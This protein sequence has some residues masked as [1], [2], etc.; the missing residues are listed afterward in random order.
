[1]ETGSKRVAYVILILLF[2]PLL[3]MIAYSSAV[4][5][6]ARPLHFDPV[7]WS[8]GSATERARMALDPSFAAAVRGKSSEEII[9]LLGQPDWEGKPEPPESRHL[10]YEVRRPL[11]F[12]RDVV[13]ILFLDDRV[14]HHSVSDIRM[15]D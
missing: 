1:M 6:A 13:Q 15:S 9:E 14:T 3:T 5:V 8:S 4:R 11:V 10:T 12:R 7:R 2:G